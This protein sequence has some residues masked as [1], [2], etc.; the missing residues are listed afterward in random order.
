[1]T[2]KL[3][4]EADH[5]GALVSTTVVYGVVLAVLDGIL[6]PFA[7]HVVHAELVRHQAKLGLSGEFTVAKSKHPETNGIVN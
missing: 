7:L 6:R 1:M 2:E 4:V 5:P 3:T